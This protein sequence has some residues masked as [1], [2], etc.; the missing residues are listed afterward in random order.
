MLCEKRNRERAATNDSRNRGND[1]LWENHRVLS[2]M[3]PLDSQ[4]ASFLC[5]KQKI[6]FQTYHKEN[7]M[8]FRVDNSGPQSANRLSNWHQNVFNKALSQ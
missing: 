2:K 6:A 7:S 3:D 1:G 5:K 8:I 4:E